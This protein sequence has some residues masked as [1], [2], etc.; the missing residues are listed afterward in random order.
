MT[1]YEEK[2]I[3]LENRTVKFSVLLIKTLAPLHKDQAMKPII[4][5]IIRSA[6]S[7]GAN[8]AE[9]N[10]A[11]SKRDF[12]NKIYISKKE[13]AETRYWLRVIKEL[14]TIQLKELEDEAKELNLIFQ[15][16]ISTM[17]ADENDK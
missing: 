5:Q 2:R 7:V 16:I 14:S 3:E 10:N 9:A 13:I 11:S 1:Q 8:Y 6:T 12:A 17:K 15:K 4:N